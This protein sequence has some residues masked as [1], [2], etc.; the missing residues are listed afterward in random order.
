M[1]GITERLACPLNAS[2]SS[3]R[4][5]LGTSIAYQSNTERALWT[6]SRKK[7]DSRKIN[8]DNP[9]DLFYEKHKLV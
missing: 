8:D 9:Y 1:S 5:S 6:N 4:L 2:K 3:P 7:Q